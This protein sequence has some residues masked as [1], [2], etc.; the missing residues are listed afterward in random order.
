VIIFSLDGEGFIRYQNPSKEKS[1][2][3]FYIDKLLFLLGLSFLHLEIKSN[4]LP[5]W[6]WK[7]NKFLILITEIAFL[8][9]VS[10]R[11][12]LLF[13]VEKGIKKHGSKYR[14]LRS[15]IIRRFV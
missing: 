13:T 14:F 10:R 8:M 2:F 11:K 15:K 3:G 5:H 7:M 1:L 12:F 4:T 6:R 9:I